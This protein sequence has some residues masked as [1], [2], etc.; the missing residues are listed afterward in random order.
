VE[1]IPLIDVLRENTPFVVLAAMFAAWLLLRTRAT[2]V[3]TGAS[4][5]DLIGGGQSAILE[6]FSN[7]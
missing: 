2:R 6:F 5:G 7:T 3:P 4:L 1:T